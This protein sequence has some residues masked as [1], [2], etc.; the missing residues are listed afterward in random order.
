RMQA[1][2]MMLQETAFQGKGQFAGKRGVYA[3]AFERREA[4]V[5][6]LI[7]IAT[8]DEADIVGS[9]NVFPRRDPHGERLTVQD[10]V[11]GQCRFAKR[12]RHAGWIAAADPAPRG[13]HKIRFSVSSIR[14]DEHDGMGMEDRMRAE[15][16]F[17][18]RSPFTGAC[19]INGFC[20]EDRV[21]SG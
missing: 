9:L 2:L 7:M 12:N 11:I 21:S 17:F 8:R 15:M 6:E 13:I 1:E 14:A 4:R 3:L 10:I 5:P 16:D 18:V 20:G 19:L